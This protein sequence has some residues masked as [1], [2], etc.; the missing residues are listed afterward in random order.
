MTTTAITGGFAVC[1]TRLGA[2]V[3][4]PKDPGA[5]LGPMFSQVVGTILRLTDR[6]AEPLARR[7]AAATTSRP[8]A[9]S[10]SSIRRRSRSNTL[11][12]L[13]RVPAGC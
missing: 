6:H 7:S 3:H 11:R 9:S 1:Q 4:D 8:T 10:A 5:D 12:L 2:K 13:S